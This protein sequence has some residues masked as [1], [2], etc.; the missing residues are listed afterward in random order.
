MYITPAHLSFLQILPFQGQD[1]I[2][3]SVLIMC[4]II[5]NTYQA[6]QRI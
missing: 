1:K 3:V 5:I 2:I 6:M 4:Y